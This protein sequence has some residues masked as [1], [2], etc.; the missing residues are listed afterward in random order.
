MECLLSNWTKYSLE[1]VEWPIVYIAFDIFLS[2]PVGRDYSSHKFR[3]VSVKYLWETDAKSRLID[4]IRTILSSKI[5]FFDPWV[6]N[7][8]IVSLSVEIKISS[9]SPSVGSATPLRFR[10]HNEV[11]TCWRD[12]PERV[13]EAGRSRPSD[14]VVEAMKATSF[15]RPECPGDRVSSRD[16]LR[17]CRTTSLL[18]IVVGQNLMVFLVMGMRLRCFHPNFYNI[19]EV[20]LGPIL[21]LAVFLRNRAAISPVNRTNPVSGHS[22]RELFACKTASARPAGVCQTKDGLCVGWRNG[23]GL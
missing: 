13:S 12:E 19:Q 20:S 3:G 15:I 9:N 11:Q 7:N 14:L 23:H 16:D 10:L 17:P 18:P 22:V 6:R 8:K 2:R 1:C 4:A 21:V 5:H